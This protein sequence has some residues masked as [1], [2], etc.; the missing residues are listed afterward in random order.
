MAGRAVR[1]PPSRPARMPRRGEREMEAP[2]LAYH[3]GR[4]S[5]KQ[6]LA[7][8]R[9]G[10]TG[11][12]RLPTARR[13]P[14]S[15]IPPSSARPATTRRDGPVTESAAPAKK[16]V[17]IAAS[18]LTQ[19]VCATLT[20]RGAAAVPES[21]PP[22]ASAPPVAFDT[23]LSRLMA[24]YQAGDAASFDALYSALAPGTAA[25]SVGADPRRRPRRGPA[26]GDLPAHAQ[27]PSHLRPGA[28]G[29]AVGLC[30]RA[31]RLPDGPSPRPPR[32]RGAAAVH[33]IHP[34]RHDR[35]GRRGR[36]RSR[37]RPSA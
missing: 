25:V 18:P 19:P 36:K 12:D 5:G 9:P 1:T 7:V 31:S 3:R 6:F 28:S 33:R 13:T 32:A 4:R 15:D 10:S 8:I 35:A 26:A 37:A 16:L 21:A 29:R 23:S 2:P 34:A 17:M 24:G 20:R 30:D 11:P 14:C 27:G 22:A